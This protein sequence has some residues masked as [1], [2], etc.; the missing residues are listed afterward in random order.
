[1]SIARSIFGPHR[2]ANCRNPL[3]HP[4]DLRSGGVPVPAI[5]AE[6]GLGLVHIEFERIEA[7]RDDFPR[8]LGIGLRREILAGMAVAIEADGVAELAAE[9]LIDR[10]AEHLAGQIP[11]GDLDAGHSGDGRAGHRAVEEAGA[12]HLLEEHVDVE[13]VFADD[14]R[15]LS[16]W[17][18]AGHP[19][20]RGCTRRSRSPLHR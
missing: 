1:M 5:V 8:A 6:A 7:Q 13:R 16:A 12:A 2:I 20:R 9:Q 3:D 10:H 18:I 17:T 19:R 15:C 11:Q 14:V 4:V